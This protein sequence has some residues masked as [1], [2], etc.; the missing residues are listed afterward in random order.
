MDGFNLDS[1]INFKALGQRLGH[2]RES[3]Q[4]T[5]DHLA[6]RTGLSVSYLS[7]VETGER[8]P[9]LT[10]LAILAQAYGVTL[11]ALFEPDDEPCI[12]IR[13]DQSVMQ[14]GNALRY[15][16]LSR[17]SRDASLQALRITVGP[18][19]VAR[20]AHE[21]EE[22]LYVLSGKLRLSVGDEQHELAAGDAAHFA[23]RVPHSFTAA[24]E[25]ITEILIVACVT[26][27]PLLTS[28]L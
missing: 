4:W 12:V 1:P 24:I 3:Q 27:H 15:A 28:Y 18:N 11:A 7:R 26:K 14:Q 8:Q 20:Y 10:T 25:Q 23:A 16:K 19:E 17:R 13:G 9:S 6:A 22:W 21:G 2:L 5:L